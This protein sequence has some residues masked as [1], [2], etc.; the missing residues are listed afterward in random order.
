MTTY[1]TSAGTVGFPTRKRKVHKL[2][3]VID[4]GSGTNYTGP[5]TGFGTGS[6]NTYTDNGLSADSPGYGQSQV[7]VQ[8]YSGTASSFKIIPLPNNTVL[9]ACGFEILVA[10]TAGNSGTLA[11][12]DGSNTFVAATACTAINSFVGTGTAYPQIYYATGATKWG[13]TSTKYL[14]V[15]TATGTI[16]GKYRVWAVVVDVND[17]QYTQRNT[18]T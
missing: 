2:S 10:D 3:D 1:T 12:T 17:E 4:F 16:N 9:L 8:G 7:N 13:A 18:F 5:V 6:T 11:L 14:Q 15:N